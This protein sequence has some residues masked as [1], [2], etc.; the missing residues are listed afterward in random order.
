MKEDDSTQE[1]KE[2]YYQRLDDTYHAFGV[3][4]CVC[5]PTLLLFIA[6]QIWWRKHKMT[7]FQL[8]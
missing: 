2:E 4:H 1:Q 7:K 6:F 5:L 3:I 8:F